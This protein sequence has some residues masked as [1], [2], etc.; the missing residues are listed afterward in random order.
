MFIEATYIRQ[1]SQHLSQANLGLE[2]LRFI[3]W[4]KEASPLNLTCV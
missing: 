4:V 3:G 1:R 2:K